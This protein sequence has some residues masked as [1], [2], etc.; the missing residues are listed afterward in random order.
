MLD[1]LRGGL[2]ISIGEDPAHVAPPKPVL[3]RV[4]VSLRIAVAVMFTMV[5]RPPQRA[6]LNSGRAAHGHQ[7]LHHATEFVA[8]MREVA[9]VASR[10]EEHTREIQRGAE[11]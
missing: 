7:E 5:A 1:H 2:A 3:W 10:Y 11:Q 4:E 6:L 8:A 9:M